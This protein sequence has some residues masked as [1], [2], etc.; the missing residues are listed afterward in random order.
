MLRSAIVLLL[1]ALATIFSACA[2]EE[3]ESEKTIKILGSGATFPQPQLE[4]WIDEYSKINPNVKIEYTGKGSGAGQ[5]D[6]K[7]GLVDFACS[8]PPVKEK[9][10]KELEKQGKPLQFPIIIGAI[11]V[12]YNVPGADDLKLS[13]DVLVDIFL[14]KIEYWDD[15]RIKELNPNINL[16]HEKIMVVHRSD[17]SGTTAVFTEYLSKISEEWRNSVGSGKVVDWP[18]DKIGRGL[19]GK[20]NAGVVAIIKQNPYT[21]GYVELAYAIKEN[22]QVALIENKEGKF[23]KPTKET[24]QEAVS[25]TS[26]NIPPP[27]EGYR[28]KIEMF[29]DAPG[30]NSYPIIAFSHMI[31]W[32]DYED[33]KAKALSDFIKW[34]MTEGQKD[35]YIIEGYV[36]LPKEVAEIGLKAA[37]M[38][39]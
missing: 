17:S 3:K 11:A 8:D 10:W 25:K 4:K 20:G 21:I 38:I 14:G 26:L 9:L 24:I 18:A 34:I 29:L 15:P 13:K 30:E 39:K 5:N 32:S 2:K 27:T 12:V 23:V 6:F 28:E 37:E 1:I 19:G 36:G 35:E 31:V 16:P 22:L 7:N 33:E